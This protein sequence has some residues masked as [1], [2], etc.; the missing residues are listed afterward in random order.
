MNKHKLITLGVTAFVFVAAMGFGAYFIVKYNE[1]N[2]DE[3]KEGSMI[4]VGIDSDFLPFGDAL[5]GRIVGMDSDIL[6]AIFHNMDLVEGEDFR[7]KIVRHGAIFSELKKGDCTVGASGISKTDYTIKR[8]AMTDTYSTDSLCA[9]S[10]VSNPGSITPSNIDSKTIAVLAHGNGEAFIENQ[11][12]DRNA[13]PA[14]VACN[15]ISE[16]V[17][18]VQDGEADLMIVEECNANWMVTS[19]SSDGDRALEIRS[20]IDIPFRSTCFAFAL[21]MENSN[22]CITMSEIMHRMSLSD[23]RNALKDVADYYLAHIADLHVPSFWDSH[24]L[25]DYVL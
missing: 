18:A 20:E 5:D 1:P 23:T 14:T 13:K 3:W 9:V 15:S 24:E 10:L 17:S 22:L 12:D 16:M 25:S 19:T 2:I 11:Y 21:N 7:F 6:R 4:T 8:F